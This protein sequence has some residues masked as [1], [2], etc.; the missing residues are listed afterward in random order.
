MAI[1][2]VNPNSV[3]L[4]KDKKNSESGGSVGMLVLVIVIAVILSLIISLAVTNF[5]SSSDLITSSDTGTISV[6]I[7]PE[8][9]STL[10]T[11]NV[12]IAEKEGDTE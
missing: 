1:K 6:H 10:G 3:V 8:F 4:G 5:L 12:E 11:V 7:Q 2:E 9:G